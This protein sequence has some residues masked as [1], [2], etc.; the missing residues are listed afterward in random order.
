MSVATIVPALVSQ[1]SFGR[2]FA[3]PETLA[4]AVIVA[5]GDG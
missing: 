5:D 1:R 2:P 3:S 4:R